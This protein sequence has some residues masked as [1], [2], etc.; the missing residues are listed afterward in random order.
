MLLHRLDFSIIAELQS[1]LKL[2]FNFLNSLSFLVSLRQFYKIVPEV[3][4]YTHIV[5]VH[6]IVV[7]IA[8]LFF[9]FI[10]QQAQC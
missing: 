10:G 1:W 4:L 8:N 7:Y 6:S 2:H 3:K 9:R 5:C